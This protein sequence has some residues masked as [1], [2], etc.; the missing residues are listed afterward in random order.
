[1]N[2]KMV[3]DIANAVLYEGYI[4]YPYR[5][6]AVKNRQRFNF[7]LLTPREYCEAFPA[8]ENASFQV[9][10]LA[11]HGSGSTLRVKV[12]FLR[13]VERSV[14][15]V[16]PPLETLPDAGFA[17]YSLVQ[18]LTVN[19]QT[20]E[21]WQEAADCA[22]E[23][24]SNIEDLLLAPRNHEFVLP[25]T[26]ECEALR[27]ADG[28]IAGVIIREQECVSGS[29][30]ISAQMAAEGIIKF[31]VRASN[32]SPVQCAESSKR[33]D[34]L[35]R[36]LI[37]AHATLNIPGGEFFS[38]IDPPRDAQMAAAACINSV[39]WPVLIG[40]DGARDAMLAS[41]IIL[42][43]YPQIAPESAGELFDGT[44]IDEILAL[45]ILTLTDEEKLEV[46]RG[47]KRAGQILERTESLPP[48]QMMKLHGALRGV[49]PVNDEAK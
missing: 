25:A 36:T 32:L 34:V 11:R 8:G 6:S 45:R 38:A 23:V 1:M 37:S 30:S 15:E 49:R 5:R 10:C 46:R 2:A 14:G 22:I 41:P 29:V 27:D 42:Y 9:E 26:K 17:S 44:E 4:L 3:E 20:H 40:E 21:P 18:R 13:L 43:D 35:R 19:N 33:E 31:S 47:D 7:G 28:K 48:E 16:T 39:V 12:R 24:Q